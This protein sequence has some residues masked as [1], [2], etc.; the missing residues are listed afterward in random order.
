VVGD[1]LAMVWI[2]YGARNNHWTHAFKLL[3]KPGE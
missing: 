2:L 3:G 1:A